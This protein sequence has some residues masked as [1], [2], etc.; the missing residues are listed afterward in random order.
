MRQHHN[1]PISSRVAFILPRYL[2]AGQESDR[3]LSSTELQN[4]GPT[5]P[6]M[7]QQAQR[8]TCPTTD[9]RSA[10][11]VIKKGLVLRLRTSRTRPEHDGVARASYAGVAPSAGRGGL[12]E[13]IA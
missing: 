2:S 5:D 1:S 10:A 11:L 6:T 7:D 4:A 13:W 12:L 9:L 3:G 8:R